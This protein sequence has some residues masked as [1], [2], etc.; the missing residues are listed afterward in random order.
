MNTTPLTPTV[1]YR[2]P[3][4]WLV[5]LFP[6]LAVVVGLFILQLAIRSNDGL[7]VDDYYREGLQINRL[8]HRDEA[9]ASLGLSAD[10]TLDAHAGEISV[11]LRARDAGT[12]LPS[13]LSLRLMH[14]TRAGLDELVTLQRQPDGRYL[15]RHHL[16]TAGHW[17]V[18]IETPR[19]RLLQSIWVAT[20]ELQAG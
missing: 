16:H 10:I 8:L 9:A 14:A 6:A 17:Y 4:V 13:L 18:Q 5:I 19:W 7:V 15:G 12:A 2:E 11:A 20:S 3:Y 1:W